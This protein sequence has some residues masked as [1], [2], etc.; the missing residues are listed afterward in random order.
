VAVVA[1]MVAA[2]CGESKPADRDNGVATI[3]G[4]AATP[5]ASAAVSEG[6]LIRTDSSADEVARFY[7]AYSDCLLSQGFDQRQARERSGTPAFRKAEAACA[8]KKPEE[9]WQRAKRL[10][11]DYADKLHEW[12]QCVKVHGIAATA[13]EDGYLSYANGLPDAKDQKSVDECQN[14]AFGTGQ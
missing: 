7:K 11:P 4:T 14:K 8:S 3:A 1:V 6:P 12:V 9:V 5:S 10:D 13:S 2:G